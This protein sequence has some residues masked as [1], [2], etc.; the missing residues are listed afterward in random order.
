MS[1]QNQIIA[2]INYV[3]EKEKIIKKNIWDG[4]IALRK[5]KKKHFRCL[6]EIL[7]IQDNQIQRAFS[8]VSAQRLGK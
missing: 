8:H 2:K 4:S 1:R 5:K 7:F 3:R 6:F